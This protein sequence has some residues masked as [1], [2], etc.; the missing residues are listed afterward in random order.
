MALI[1]MFGLTGYL[2]WE[3]MYGHTDSIYGVWDLGENI[4]VELR[5]NNRFSF[6]VK[7]GQLD[8]ESLTGVFSYNEKE[9]QIVFHRNDDAV[10][11]WDQVSVEANTLSF[12]LN[13]TRQTYFRVGATTDREIDVMKGEKVLTVFPFTKQLAD[14][15]SED[16]DL[17]SR[18]N[19]LG[20]F[21]NSHEGFEGAVLF[22]D[23]GE[24]AFYPYI[25]AD[26]WDN[27]VAYESF[28][29]V[30]NTDAISKAGYIS[31]ENGP[32]VFQ[33]VEE[34][35]RIQV[36]TEQ[37]FA[38]VLVRTPNELIDQYMGQWKK[39]GDFMAIQEGYQG[40][41]LYRKLQGSD[42]YYDYFMRVAWSSIESFEVIEASEFFQSIVSNRAYESR[43]ALYKVASQDQRGVIKKG[44]SPNVTCA[45]LS[46][47]VDPDRNRD[48][49]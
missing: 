10:F 24:D 5:D 41:E 29:R 43:T 9:R 22:E 6:Y 31:H 14:D 44:L 32:G 18:W 27:A 26:C 28:S 48:S 37:V 11:S 7:V 19:A 15:L 3:I 38:L 46:R 20:S 36:A 4:D 1:T 33:I 47:V 23:T 8:Q 40:N 16:W 30:F 2:T 12:V 34:S 17:A 49:N 35:G 42:G 39:L 21:R 13:D 25:T 45:N